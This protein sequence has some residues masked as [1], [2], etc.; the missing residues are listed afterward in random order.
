MDAQK[1]RTAGK[2]LASCLAALALVGMTTATAA[3]T[4]R[5]DL[6]WSAPFTN[7]YSDAQLDFPGLKGFCREKGGTVVRYWVHD[8]VNNPP[9]R[10]FKAW[11]ACQDME[12]RG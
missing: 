9:S 7:S 3:A 12:L 1:K 2:L 4:T 6:V 11:I 5:G 10:R 8:Y